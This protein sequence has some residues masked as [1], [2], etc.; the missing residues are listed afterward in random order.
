M[1]RL[2]DPITALKGIG[3]AKEKQFAALGVYTVYDLITHFP[4]AYEDRTRLVTIDRLEVDVPG[5]FRAMVTSSPQP[6]PAGA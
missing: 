6:H 2:T 4:R 1:P 3:A 5:C